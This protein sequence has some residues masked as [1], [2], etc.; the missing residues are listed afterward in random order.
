MNYADLIGKDCIKIIYNYKYEM[1]IIEPYEQI[2][3]LFQ[4][5]LN[6]NK[7]KKFKNKNKNISLSS[8]RK[9]VL[10]R[11]DDMVLDLSISIKYKYLINAFTER[12][13]VHNINYFMATTFFDIFYEN[14][15]IIAFQKN[16]NQE[17]D[18][19]IYIDYN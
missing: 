19:I 18:I 13:G 6:S 2:Y 12:I 5:C 9:Y 16:R 8:F 1:E 4:Q 17:T 14:Y 7:R 10:L 11:N 15:T 3:D